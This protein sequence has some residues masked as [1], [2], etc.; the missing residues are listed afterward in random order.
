LGGIGMDSLS[1]NTSTNRGF[2]GT[3]RSIFIKNNVEHGMT[4]GKEHKDYMDSMDEAMRSLE[5]IETLFNSTSDPD[6]IEYAIYEQ[7]AIKL[8]LSY[9]IKKA[10]ENN[11]KSISY[12]SI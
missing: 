8:K 9:L 7:Y 5:N 12:T 4:A 3:I 2:S 10:K 11:I 6:L 1:T